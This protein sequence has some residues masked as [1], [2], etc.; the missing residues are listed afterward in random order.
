MSIEAIKKQLLAIP[1]IAAWPEIAA[2]VEKPLRQQLINCFDYPGIAARSLGQ[3]VAGTW[4]ASAAILCSL[5]S[6]HLVDDML[7][8]DPRGAYHKWGA[9]KAANIALALQATAAQVLAE[10]AP[11]ERQAAL[12]RCLAKMSIATAWGQQLDAEDHPGEEAY[13]RTTRLKTPPLFG[14]ALELGAL[15]AGAPDSLAAAIGAL[16]LPIGEMIQV[17]DDLHDALEVPACPDWF[18]QGGN[19]AILYARLAPH[20]QRERFEALRQRVSDEK[21]LREAQDLMI[22]CGGVSYCAYSL[23]EI[24]KKGRKMVDELDV[25]DRAPLIELVDCQVQA[26]LELLRKL[27]VAAPEELLRS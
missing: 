26:V 6:I 8:E 9:G 21:A 19:L 16:G 25:V 15:L 5:A 11:P 12:H 13:W 24:Y 7:D 14:G 22:E 1:E 20:P 23:L 27:G 18:R 10:N 3:G 2:L 4:P 17:N